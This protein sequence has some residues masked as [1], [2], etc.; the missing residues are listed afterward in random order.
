[1]SDAHAP[2]FRRAVLALNGGTSDARIVRLVADYARH[3]KAEL[4]AVHVVEIDWTLP[5][6]AESVCVHGDGPNATEIAAALRGA[7]LALDFEV[8]AIPRDDA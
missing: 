1:M 7:A 6:D 3:A 2:A 8:A 5:L 4:V